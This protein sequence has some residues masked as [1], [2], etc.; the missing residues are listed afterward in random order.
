MNVIPANASN[1]E[2]TFADS[3]KV[4]L[5]G[6]SASGSVQF[7]IRPEHLHEAPEAEAVFVGK[8]TNVERLGEHAI[9]HVDIGTSEPM[10]AKLSNET[11]AAKGRRLGLGFDHERALLF[12]AD[13][14]ALPLA[15]AAAA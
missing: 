8:V 9:V 2:L 7:G 3:R 6:H 12:G 10:V 1:S 11:T 5:P 4:I 15:A 14:N 13:G